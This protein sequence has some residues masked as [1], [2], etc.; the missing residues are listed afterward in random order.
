MQ[1]SG[2]NLTWNHSQC[3]PHTKSICHH[4]GALN[5]RV[6]LAGKQHANPENVFPFETVKPFPAGTGVRQF[7]MRDP[8]Q[9]FCLFLCSP[10]AHS[11]WSHGAVARRAGLSD[12]V[13]VNPERITLPPT[14]HDNPI[15]RKTY[16]DYQTTGKG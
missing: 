2:I 15:T 11:P 8:K 5:Y 12:M 3:K 14:F 6:G 7:I 16:V 1:K 9:P 13:K 10:L 4:L